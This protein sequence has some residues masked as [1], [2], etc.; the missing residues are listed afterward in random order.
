MEKRSFEIISPQASPDQVDAIMRRRAAGNAGP[1]CVA[2]YAAYAVDYQ[3]QNGLLNF[4]RTL[5]RTLRH[6]GE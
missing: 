5:I 1:V 4:L 3:H 2:R 6:L